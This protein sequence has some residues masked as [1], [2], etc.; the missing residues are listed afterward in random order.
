MTFYYR[1]YGG[2]ASQQLVNFFPENSHKTLSDKLS[3]EDLF[4]ATET[5]DEKTTKGRRCEAYC[6]AAERRQILGNVEGA[7]DFYRRCLD[8][9]QKNYLET[10]LAEKRLED[11]DRK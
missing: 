7:K 10:Y 11:L 6:F 2:R 9:N 4:K 1:V 5:K 3:E 8:Q